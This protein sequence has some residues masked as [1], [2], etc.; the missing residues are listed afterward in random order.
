V[1]DESELM[2]GFC[3]SMFIAYLEVQLAFDGVLGIMT[4]LHV[5][6]RTF[7]MHWRLL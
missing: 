4:W 1:R 2:S 6:E 5:C 7:C 3:M